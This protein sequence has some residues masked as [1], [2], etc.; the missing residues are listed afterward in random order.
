MHF[1]PFL[2]YLELDRVFVMIISTFTM[3]IWLS[4]DQ[5][6]EFEFVSSISSLLNYLLPCTC[7]CFLMRIK[8]SFKCCIYVGFRT[9]NFEP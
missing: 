2:F 5:A 9:V 8:L 3:L 4:H 1:A 7:A 6:L